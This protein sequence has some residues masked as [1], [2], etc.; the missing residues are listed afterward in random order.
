[1]YRS[2]AKNVSAVFSVTVSSNSW[3]S[4]CPV[5]NAV[6]VV[7]EDSDVKPPPV[8]MSSLRGHR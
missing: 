4:S 3:K 2:P 7:R 8:K 1:L 5:P 6:D